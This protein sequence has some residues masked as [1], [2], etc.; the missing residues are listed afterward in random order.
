MLDPDLMTDLDRPCRSLPLAALALLCLV[1]DA[2]FGL[3]WLA[4]WI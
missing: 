1:F 3:G 4:A 2:G